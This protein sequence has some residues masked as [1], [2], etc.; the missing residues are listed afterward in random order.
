MSAADG[1]RHGLGKVRSTM[2]L[3]KVVVGELRRRFVDLR[4]P[5]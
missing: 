1:A 3:I 5:Y 4:S 2:A